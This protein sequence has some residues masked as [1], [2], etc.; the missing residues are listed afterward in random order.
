MNREAVDNGKHLV[1]EGICIYYF[2]IRV[3]I[4]S[5]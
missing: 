3:V 2:W 1:V 5:V 4:I